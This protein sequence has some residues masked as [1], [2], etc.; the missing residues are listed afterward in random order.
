MGNRKS[1]TMN[2]VIFW[3][4]H[5]TLA[6]NDWMI[7]K[8]LYKVLQENEPDCNISIDQIKKT[9]ILGFPWH[10]PE[11]EY[12][13]LTKPEAWWELAEKILSDVYTGL[14][15]DDE[16]AK[17]YASKAHYELVKSDEFK[18]YDDTIEVLKHFNCKGYF[19]VIL[20]NH[21]PELPDI[22]K[23]LGLGDYIHACISSANIGFEKPNPRIYEYALNKVNHPKVSWMVGDSMECDVKGPEAVG[24]KGVL[25]RSDNKYGTEYYSK[26]LVGLKEIIL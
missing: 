18:L 20:S 11:K 5:G 14:D 4:F 7:S 22:A 2:K 21:I 19:N 1:A 10:N 17:L 3:D 12:L 24:I 23:Q 15:I 8:A 16:K 26:D 6:Y 13:N 9:P 25:V